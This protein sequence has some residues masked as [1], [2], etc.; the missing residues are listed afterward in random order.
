M[1]SHPISID[2]VSYRIISIDSCSTAHNKHKM[3]NIPETAKSRK[4]CKRLTNARLWG[5]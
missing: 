1:F 3:S 4:L 2:I 5:M